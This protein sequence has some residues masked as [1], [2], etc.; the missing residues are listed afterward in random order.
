M[1]LSEIAQ[2][3]PR[4][5]FARSWVATTTVATILDGSN[6][7]GG[8]VAAISCRSNEPCHDLGREQPR[9]RT[10]CRHAG[11]S[12]PGLESLVAPGEQAQPAD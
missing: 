8:L 12:K 1:G 6:Q 9:R 3:K 7:E 10:G 2:T 4:V 11:S 5:L